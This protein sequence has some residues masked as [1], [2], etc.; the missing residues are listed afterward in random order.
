[1]SLIQKMRAIQEHKAT[2]VCVGLDPDLSK[3]PAHLTTS[4][5]PA[6]AIVAFNQAII[7]S[8]APFACAFKPNFAFYERYGSAGWEALE[9]TIELLPDDVITIADAKRGDIG[10]TGSFYAE[11]IYSQLGFD[12]VTISPYMGMDAIEPFLAYPDKLAFVLGRTSNPGAS[13]IQ[14]LVLDDQPI[15]EHVIRRIAGMS[16]KNRERIGLVVGATDQVA[17]RQIR[18]LMPTT[19]FLIPGVG[20]Q[21]GD[22]KTV[23]KAAYA[24]PGSVIINSSRGILYA[25]TSTAFAEIAAFEAKKLRDTIQTA[26]DVNQA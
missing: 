11:S 23:I 16:E 15:Y 10:N 8:T 9:K 25:D 14:E 1:M 18:T 12:T 13:H 26:I 22:P 4:M 6:D 5:A 24:G 20:A 2:T 19:P 17:L 21:G 7:A 3:M